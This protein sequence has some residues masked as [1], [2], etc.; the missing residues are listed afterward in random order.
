MKIFLTGGTGFNGSNLLKRIEDTNKILLLT[1]QQNYKS[2]SKN[3]DFVYGDLS[4]V[5]TWENKLEKFMPDAAVHLA[6]DGIPNDYSPEMSA[7]NL[8]NSLNLMIS[9]SKIE[10]SKIIVS[11]TC[12]EYGRKE[13]ELDETIEPKPFK[14]LAIAKNSLYQMTKELVKEKNID[15]IW[16]RFFY[17]YGSGRGKI[18]LVPYIINSIK[19][20]QKPEIKNPFSKY[21]F[22]YSEDVADALSMIIQKSD[23]SA[24]YNIGSGKSTSILDIS[25]MI[26]DKLNIPYNLEFHKQ[27]N[28]HFDN[29]WADI[30]KIKNEIG[31]EPKI[32]LEDGI[33]KTILS[34]NQ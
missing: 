11:G 19:K 13:G 29:F 15:L 30:K 7:K 8:R 9:L 1:R 4:D 24:V 33:E 21:D 10:C 2:F 34:L 18:T 22:V 17:I 3:V 5:S 25:K 6:W 23:K 26:Y 16:A 14:P 28:K 27:D 20:N 31:W 32:S 12:W